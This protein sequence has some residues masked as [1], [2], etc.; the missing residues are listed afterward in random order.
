MSCFLTMSYGSIG[1][2]LSFFIKYQVKM[3]EE[4]IVAEDFKEIFG[5]ESEEYLLSFPFPIS[6]F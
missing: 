1:H 2:G 6:E 5:E 3:V 4:S